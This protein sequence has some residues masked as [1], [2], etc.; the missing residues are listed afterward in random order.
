ME[1]FVLWTP[2]RSS[3]FFCD[4]KLACD[5]FNSKILFWEWVGQ[6]E[7]G[8]DSAAVLYFGTV[9]LPTIYCQFCFLLLLNTTYAVLGSE[10]VSLH[11]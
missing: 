4:V 1:W 5:F 6:N 9:C 2:F 11:L 7:K 10:A 3:T 8:L